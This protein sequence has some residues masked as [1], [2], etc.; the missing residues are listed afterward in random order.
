[1]LVKLFP[2]IECNCS[3]TSA[4][5]AALCNSGKLIRSK[6]Q[7][8]SYYRL[9]GPDDTAKATKGG[10]RPTN[11][12]NGAFIPPKETKDHSVFLLAF[13]DHNRQFRGFSVSKL[14]DALMKYKREAH[15]DDALHQARIFINYLK[16]YHEDCLLVE[17]HGKSVYYSIFDF[18]S[19]KLN[20]E[21][22]KIDPTSN[23]FDRP[24]LLEVKPLAVVSDPPQQEPIPPA[25]L[26]MGEPWP[27]VAYDE[28]AELLT[29]AEAIQACNNRMA[30]IE[31][32]ISSLEK[33]LIAEKATR[34][35]LVNSL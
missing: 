3:T 7:G 26:P 16:I 4:A 9:S 29:K 2:M 14:A 18:E 13:L 27:P 21:F 23:I 19:I 6:K 15:R 22:P 31:E 20:H 30:S 28:K 17:R 1:M 8:Y 25:S 11:V 33:C 34:E 32:Q 5:L 12:A 24:P 35:K 10:Q